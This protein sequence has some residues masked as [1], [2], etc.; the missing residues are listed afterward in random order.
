[1][2]HAFPFSNLNHFKSATV[3]LRF[4]PEKQ[5]PQVQFPPKIAYLFRC[6]E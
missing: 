4:S 3:R 2:L 5:Q 6:E 1:M